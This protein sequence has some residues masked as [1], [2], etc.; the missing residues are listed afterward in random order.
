[1]PQRACAAI[2][3]MSE[4][5]LAVRLAARVS[6]PSRPPFR[7]N[8]TAWGFFRFAMSKTYLIA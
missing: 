1:M 5:S 8:A 6:P 2:L 4:R 3:A 7:P